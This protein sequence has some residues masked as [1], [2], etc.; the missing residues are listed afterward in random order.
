MSDIR[1]Q[2]G[3]LIYDLTS[4]EALT[5]ADIIPISTNYLTRSITLSQLKIYTNAGIYTSQ[6]VDELIDTLVN[7][8]I[9][10]INKDIFD[11]RNDITEFRNEFTTKLSDL[12]DELFKTVNDNDQKFTDITNK[13]RI[14]LTDLETRFNEKIIIGN[15]VPTTLKPGQ[16]YLQYF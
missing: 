11:L 9:V 1:S 14:D 13:L 2:S 5:D 15:Q 4:A 6:E 10:S 7:D 3:K 16:V 8:K 12:S